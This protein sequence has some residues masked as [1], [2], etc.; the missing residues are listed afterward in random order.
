ARPPPS[1]ARETRPAPGSPDRSAARS[2][3]APA[4]PAAGVRRSGRAGRRTTEPESEPPPPVPTG[5]GCR[6]PDVEG[7]RPPSRLLHEGVDDLLLARLIEGH[8]QFVAFDGADVAVAELLVEDAV[9]AR[10][11]GRRLGIGGGDQAAFA[12][13]HGAAGVGGLGRLVR[14]IGLGAFPAGTGIAAAEGG[15]AFPADPGLLDPGRGAVVAGVRLR[16]DVGDRQFIDEA[17][18][19]LRGPAAIDHAV[20]GEAD[21]RILLGAGDADVGQ[22]AFLL[23]P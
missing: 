3:E 8:D 21:A 10:P 9:A 19:Q 14:G 22:T 23:Q 15:G 16:L 20:G 13:D 12:L 6:R 1:A 11:A 4:F 17:A 18:G 5:W 2:A 7:R